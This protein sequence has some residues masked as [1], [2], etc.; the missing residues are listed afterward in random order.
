MHDDITMVLFDDDVVLRLLTEQDLEEMQSKP[1]TEDAVLA[2]IVQRYAKPEELSEEVYVKEM[3]R[4]WGFPPNFESLKVP[5]IQ[6]KSLLQFIENHMKGKYRLGLVVADK[7]SARATLGSDYIELFDDLIEYKELEKKLQ[8]YFDN[9][10]HVVSDADTEAALAGV[11]YLHVYRSPLELETFL[12]EPS[13]HGRHIG[14][15]N[16]MPASVQ[17]AY[18]FEQTLRNIPKSVQYVID[19][20]I[21][22]AIGIGLVAWLEPEVF[23]QAVEQARE[24]VGN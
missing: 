24:W 14:V 1:G 13:V 17:S 23:D 8:Y 5:Y 16:T 2:S 6:N 4:A 3:L 22:V 7:K 11:K 19:V 10:L 21:L 9:V 15:E 12:N 20:V 18:T